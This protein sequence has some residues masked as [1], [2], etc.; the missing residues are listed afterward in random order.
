MRGEEDEGGD[1]EMKREEKTG[2]DLKYLSFSRQRG[3]LNFARW[4][5][6]LVISTILSPMKRADE[7]F[8]SPLGVSR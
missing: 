4:I 8:S 6:Y 1:D 5:V 2:R 7:Y 3:T